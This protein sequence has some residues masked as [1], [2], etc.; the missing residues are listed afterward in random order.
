M[1]PHQ[2]PAARFLP[3]WLAES[4]LWRLI[5]AHGA[6]GGQS[7][8]AFAIRV[9]GAFIALVSQILMARWM[10]GTEYG[11]F[12]LVWV[13]GLITGNLSCLGLH[14]LVIRFLPQYLRDRR[15]DEL[16]GLL[17]W[18][19]SV[20]LIASILVAFAGAGAVLLLSER[21]EPFYHLPLLLVAAM[22][23]VLALS[24]LMQGMARGQGAVVSGLAP[25]YVARPLLILGI[26]GVCVLAGLRPDAPTA[27]VATLAASAATSALQWMQMSRR[28]RL[29][30]ADGPRDFAEKRL[31]I[32]V[33]APIFLV[34]SFFFLL[35]N[36]DVV[37]VGFLLSPEDVAIYFA[38]AKTM[39]VA[40]FVYFAVKA[41]VAP[42]FAQYAGGSGDRGPGELARM[43]AHWTFWPTLGIA[44]VLLAAGEF[45][46]GLFG[47]EFRQGYPL[48]FL[49]AA[50]ILARAALGPAETALTMSGHHTL[51]ALVYGLALAVTIGL[52]ILLVPACGLS[53]AALATSIGMVIET[54]FLGFAV[55]YRLGIVMLVLPRRTRNRA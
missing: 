3:S 21:I 9:I 45:L 25:V 49:L 22:V 6:A 36:A 2:D 19:R 54:L 28:L 24:D 37:L 42:Q 10:G 39:A 48:M 26:F 34:E 5:G 14:T 11:I 23:P 43:S 38:A 1:K 18:T 31:W 44:L 30:I 16:R 50:G 8:L 52:N 33:A 17:V 35:S 40:H 47:A 32:A 29:R 7:I 41:G 46:L 55:W 20:T 51:C 27:I 13:I 53:G 12:V 15:H 4:R